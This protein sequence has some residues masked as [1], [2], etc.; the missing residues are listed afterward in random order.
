MT[1]IEVLMSLAIV[2]VV[3][4]AA[5]GVLS[6][7]A[8]A[9]PARDTAED[10]RTR[11]NQALAQLSQEISE[12][13]SF[14]LLTSNAVQ[15][16]VADRTE[17]GVEEI[18]RYEFGAGG[19]ASLSRTF[20]GSASGDMLTNVA[21]FRIE[22]V[23]VDRSRMIAG[24]PEW[25]SEK[26]LAS[27]LGATDGQLMVNGAPF[28]TSAAAQVVLPMLAENVTDWSPTRIELALLR[29]T[30]YTPT[31]TIEV[32]RVTGADEPSL[33]PGPSFDIDGST[34]SKT[35][36]TWFA[37]SVPTFV[38]YPRSSPVAIVIRPK[39]AMTQGIIVP[40]ASSVAGDV[41]HLCNWSAFTWNTQP[42]A[43]TMFKLWGKTI[44][45]TR[46]SEAWTAV[47]ELT[48]TAALATGASGTTT[49]RLLNE[50]EVP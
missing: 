24:A 45:P 15:F 6:F 49:V 46:T 10:A 21:A 12:A 37:G 50:P 34:A 7:A 30:T 3:M 22:N 23:T 48:F 31:M 35:V 26:L 4:A 44:A 38:S 19:S 36:P 5:S 17:D 25:S 33:L 18:I 40:T 29:S 13:T 47:S 43:G 14:T 41:Q 11:V 2:A 16:T 8:R 28:T 9:L 1:L 32:R 20:N 42:N 39:N 27:Y